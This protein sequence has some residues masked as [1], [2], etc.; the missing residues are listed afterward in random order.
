MA[1]A[2][3]R[4]VGAAQMYGPPSRQRRPPHVTGTRCRKP[5]LRRRW[6]A[7]AS[8]GK[9]AIKLADVFRWR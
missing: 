2:R 3:F 1:G 7:A 4:G 5:W 6:A 8:S 9:A